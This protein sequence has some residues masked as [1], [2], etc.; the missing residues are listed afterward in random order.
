MEWRVPYCLLM[1]T[2][3]VQ[4][5]SGFSWS[6]SQIMLITRTGTALQLK[7]SLHTP[8]NIAD[9]KRK[10]HLLHLP[11]SNLFV[12]R[13]TVMVELLDCIE[14]FRT[15]FIR[16]C[17]ARRQWMLTINTLAAKRSCF[18]SNSALC[19][20][21][22]LSVRDMHSPHGRW[23]ENKAAAWRNCQK[24]IRGIVECVFLICM[25]KQ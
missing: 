12:W 5:A 16:R 9:L 6:E 15:W 3:I 14:A 17:V 22:I 4:T 13:W 8:S 20:L 24:P 10:T 19:V 2:V 21:F 25:Q 11:S 7:N 1:Y 23:Y 18:E